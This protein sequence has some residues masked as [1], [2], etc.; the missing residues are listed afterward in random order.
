MSIQAGPQGFP[1]ARRIEGSPPVS[2]VVAGICALLGGLVGLVWVQMGLAGLRAVDKMRDPKVDIDW[3]GRQLENQLEL[4][5]GAVFVVLLGLGGV[6]LLAR[7]AAGL[8]MVTIGSGLGFFACVGPLIV[9]D[10]LA[11]KGIHAGLAVGCVLI[12]VT[13]LLPATD[14]WIESGKNAQLMPVHTPRSPVPP[15]N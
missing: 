4:G 12:L 5:I 11:L 9:E 3:D 8:T 2:A 14:R 13:A 10:D 7:R 1:P 15:Y 6:L